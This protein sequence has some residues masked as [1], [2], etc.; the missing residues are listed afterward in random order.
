MKHLK[1]KLVSRG[2]LVAPLLVVGTGAAL[3]TDPPPLIDLSTAIEGIPTTAADVL[4]DNAAALFTMLAFFVG[5]AL[6]LRLV[7]KF[8][9]RTR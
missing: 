6:I 9:A 5:L 7:R 4:S 8:G 2:V 1:S 3:A